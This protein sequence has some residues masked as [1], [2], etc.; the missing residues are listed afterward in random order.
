MHIDMPFFSVLGKP[1]NLTR[2]GH[3]MKKLLSI[4]LFF[5]MNYTWAQ[6]G[7]FNSDYAYRQIEILKLHDKSSY[8]LETMKM[9][10][11]ERELTCK[12]ESHSF[13]PEFSKTATFV[14]KCHSIHDPSQKYKVKI[15]S[16]FKY[17]YGDVALKSLKFTPKNVTFKKRR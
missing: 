6:L 7:D 12:G 11:T 8:V 17:E 3:S 13:F 10:E 9:I 2:I 16:K 14:A 15:K 5:S 1:N 4:I